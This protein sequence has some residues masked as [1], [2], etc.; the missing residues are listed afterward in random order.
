[1]LTPVERNALADARRRFVEWRA[2]W[3]DDGAAVDPK[4]LAALRKAA[5]EFHAALQPLLASATGNARRLRV[6]M[7][8]LE[9]HQKHQAD[10]VRD[11]VACCLTADLIDKACAGEVKPGVKADA[12]TRTWVWCAADAWQAAG[13]RVSR[14]GRFSDALQNYKHRD[15]P[16]AGADQIK[17]AVT[18]WGATKCGQLQSSIAPDKTTEKPS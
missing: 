16:A 13:C 7:Q 6:R 9:L 15:V 8:Q 17:A 2:Q 12:L 10:Y 4:A 18:D 14:T 5:R 1:M 3:H 11:L